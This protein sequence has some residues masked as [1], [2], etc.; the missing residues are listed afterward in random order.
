MRHKSA[1]ETLVFLPGMMCDRRLFSPQIEALQDRYEIIVPTLV[2]PSIELMAKE[3]LAQVRVPR[4]NAVGLSMGGIVAMALAGLAPERISRMALLDTNHLI[5]APDRY[6]IRNRQIDDVK[7]GRLRDVIV[8][9]MKPNYL[10][11][12]HRD[13][14]SLLDLLVRM[15]E[16]VGPEAFVG[17]SIALR[18][19]PDQTRNLVTYQG[20]TLVLC[21]E[22]DLLCPPQRHREIAGLLSNPVLEMIPNAGHITTLEA[23]SRVNGALAR[24]LAS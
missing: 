12:R 17:Q 1:G 14:Q 2:S 11:A 21:G 19:R 8:E 5:D 3:V 23:A 6:Y 7:A 20:H 4:F 18:D 24:W 16:D 9:E 22:E 15:A 10:A 13:N